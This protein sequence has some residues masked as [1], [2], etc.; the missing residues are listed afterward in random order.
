LHGMKERRMFRLGLYEAPTGRQETPSLGGRCC[1][2]ADF[3]CRLRLT[4]I[5]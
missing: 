3:S 4:G 5:V 1:F 2:L